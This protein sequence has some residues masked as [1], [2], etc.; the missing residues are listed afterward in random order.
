MN[1]ILEYKTYYASVNFSAKDEVFYG[2]IIGINDSV[3]FEGTTVRELKNAFHEAVDDYLEACKEVGKEPEKTY[4]GSFNVRI[5]AELH[6]EVAKQAAQQNMSLNDF[7]RYA[8]DFTLNKTLNRRTNAIILVGLSF[9][10]PALLAGI[11]LH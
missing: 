3:T 8:L 7:V 4:K 5:S 11:F 10:L 6:R 1:E 9:F 2:K